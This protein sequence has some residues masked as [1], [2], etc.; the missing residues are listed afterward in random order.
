MASDRPLLERDKLF[1]VAH[2]YRA[3]ELVTREVGCMWDGNGLA[4]RWFRGSHDP[5]K[6]DRASDLTIVCRRSVS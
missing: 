4:E 6:V 3:R 1:D 5:S 2:L